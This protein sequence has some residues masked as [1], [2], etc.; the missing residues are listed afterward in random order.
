VELVFLDG[1]PHQGF[2]GEPRSILD[3]AGPVT[4]RC[5]EAPGRL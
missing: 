1:S 4:F 5:E 2:F 3:F